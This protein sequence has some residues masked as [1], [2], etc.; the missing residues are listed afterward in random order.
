MA[1]RNRI[2]RHLFCHRLLACLPCLLLPVF[3]LCASPAKASAWYIDNPYK[4][5]D[6]EKDLR[7][8]SNLHAH[9]TMS[10]GEFEPKKVIDRYRALGYTVLSLTDHDTGGQ[11]GNKPGPIPGKTTWPWQDFDRD[12]GTAGMIAV[13]GNEISRRHH[14]GSFFNGYGNP[15]LVSEESAL[16]E[17]RQR[18]GLAVFFHPGRYNKTV[19]WYL[20]LYKRHP[21][22]IGLE[23]Y[24][25]NDRYPQ[26]RGTWDA[27]LSALSDSRPVWG[28]ANDDMH[29]P[30]TQLGYSWNILLLPDLTPA[31]VRR[32]MVQG[33]FFY[34]HAPQ[35]HNGPP[36]PWIERIKVDE[37]R[38]II[39]IKAVG[40]SAVSWL[41]GGE[42][43]YHGEVIDLSLVPESCKYVRAEVLSG[44]AGLVVGTQPFRIRRPK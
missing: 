32:A 5:V 39:S 4:D 35:G 20:D 22:L 25:Q 9:T 29:N 3:L 1:P 10:D 17:I 19:A 27:I 6:W 37:A 41:C 30:K 2:A 8:K 43:V 28:F 16:D 24:N 26:D 36:P 23:I 21:H 31:W 44:T 7:S 13:E 18:D 33:R 12:P 15:D 11:R 38:G 42:F 34:V 40:H 14:F